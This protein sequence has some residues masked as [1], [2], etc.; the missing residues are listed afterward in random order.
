[1]DGEA[2]EAEVTDGG[3]RVDGELVQAVLA[4][5][6]GTPLV[7]LAVDA[8]VHAIAVRRDEGRGRFT[9]W[10]AERRIAVEALDERTHAIRELAAASRSAQGPAPLVAPMPGL[11]VRVSVVPGDAVQ[12]GQ[13][14]VVME[15]MKMENEL[16]A[17][18]AGTVTAVRVTP[19]NAVEKGAILVELS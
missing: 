1:V 7:T 4:P 16:R 2:V 9:L 17:P 3:V 14:L 12:A 5:V 18:S 8:S 6:Q 13:G 15:A 10:T 11:I 19:G